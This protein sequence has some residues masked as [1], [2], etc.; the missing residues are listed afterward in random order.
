MKK[1][2]LMFIGPKGVGKTKIVN[3]VKRFIDNQLFLDITVFN[4]IDEHA[5]INSSCKIIFVIDENN[6]EWIDTI[7][8]IVKK[9][10]VFIIVSPKSMWYGY[11]LQQLRPITDIHPSYI[12]DLNNEDT[13]KQAF[14]NILKIIEN[15]EQIKYSPEKKNE[16]CCGCNVS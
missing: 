5:V 15:D 13:I 16:A 14:D 12:I 3:C 9:R 4:G 6:Y 8:T 11:L 2:K 1:T 7:S 10:P